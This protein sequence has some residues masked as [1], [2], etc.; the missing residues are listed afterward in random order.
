MPVTITHTLGRSANHAGLLLGHGVEIH[1][2]D[3]A[4]TAV[5]GVP[6]PEGLPRPYGIVV[7]RTRGGFQGRSTS[8][9]SD[10]TVSNVA[11]KSP[12]TVMWAISSRRQVRFMSQGRA[13]SISSC[14]LGANRNMRQ[15]NPVR[16]KGRLHGVTGDRR[17]SQAQSS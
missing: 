8:G 3:T 16:L 2:G 10:P 15:E 12:D 7:I 4:T 13:A 11:E 14:L 9:S 6:G 17:V 1:Y 5:T